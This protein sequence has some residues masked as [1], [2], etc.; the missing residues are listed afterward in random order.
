MKTEGNYIEYPSMLISADSIST[1]HSSTTKKTKLQQQFNRSSQVS[2]TQKF[3]D[4][5]RVN[6]YTYLNSY[7][8]GSSVERNLQSQYSKSRGKAL[9][10]SDLL[11][12]LSKEAEKQIHSSPSKPEIL[13]DQFI[14]S[15]KISLTKPST[16]KKKRMPEKTNDDSAKT[17]VLYKQN[18]VLNLQEPKKSFKPES[19]TWVLPTIRAK[20]SKMQRMQT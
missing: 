11:K 20:L 2:L 8:Q 3:V 9:W 6:S 4:L 14:K 1:E 19:E 7:H 5:P 18:L 10:V 16:P 13:I 17:K 12:I 15:D